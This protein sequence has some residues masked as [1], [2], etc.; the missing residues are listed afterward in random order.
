MGRAPPLARDV[1]AV[2][3]L[4]AWVGVTHFGLA[5]R[6]GFSPLEGPEPVRCCAAALMW[7]CLRLALVLCCCFVLSTEIFGPVFLCIV[8]VTCCRP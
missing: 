5:T 2:L 4:L 8:V 3:S 1:A 6:S 7:L